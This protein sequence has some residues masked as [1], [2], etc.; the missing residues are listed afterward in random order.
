[1]IT[2]I[3]KN[4]IN[5]L[6]NSFLSK[7]DI[8]K[9]LDQNPFAKIIVLKEQEKIIGY[10][11][12]SEIY[13]RIEIN[14]FEVEETMRNCGK[15]QQLLSYLINTVEKDIS[16]EVKEDNYSAIHLYEKNGFTKSAIRPNYY[17]GTDGILMIR[18]KEKTL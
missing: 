13:E 18:N 5:E 4:N 8:I 12:Y 17:N 2:E 11:Y 9:E 7:E 14:Q 15:G 3:T 1:M 6:D 16:L 10:L